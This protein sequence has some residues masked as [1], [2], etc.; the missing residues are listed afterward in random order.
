MGESSLPPLHAAFSSGLPIL[1]DIS[2]CRTSMH[3]LQ[4]VPRRHCGC[5]QLAASVQCQPWLPHLFH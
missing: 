3:G 1:H 2:C 5:I 4:G